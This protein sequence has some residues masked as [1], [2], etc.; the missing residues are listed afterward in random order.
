MRRIIL[1]LTTTA[2]MVSLLVSS[3]LPAM[4]RGVGDDFELN[5]LGCVDP[6]SGLCTY[7]PGSDDVFFPEEAQQGSAERGFIVGKPSR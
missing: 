4:A 3:A 1:F 5:F 6:E 2:L 7:G